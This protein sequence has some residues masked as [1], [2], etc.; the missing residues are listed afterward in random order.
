[1]EDDNEPP[2]TTRLLSE[3]GEDFFGK[4]PFSVLQKDSADEHAALI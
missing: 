3:A 2:L 1:V 4:H